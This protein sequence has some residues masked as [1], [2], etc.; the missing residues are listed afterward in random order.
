MATTI[1]PAEQVGNLP[2]P[3]VDW[4]DGITISP[5]LPSLDGASGLSSSVSSAS[6]SAPSMINANGGYGYG[7]Y[8]NIVSTPTD[9]RFLLSTRGYTG[10]VTEGSGS[11]GQGFEDVQ[12]MI[13][14][15]ILGA[16]PS[17]S[18]AQ[19][20]FFRSKHAPVMYV[21]LEGLTGSE[22]LSE[23]SAL[24]AEGVIVEE[25]I[26]VHALQGHG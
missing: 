22:L 21:D 12:A 6:A 14:S 4:A 18:T 9:R 1:N 8:D 20:S 10:S 23:I 16:I 26:R 25:D 19:A 15:T 24:E 5:L 3:Q 17:S 2:A 11:N 7:Y 13:E